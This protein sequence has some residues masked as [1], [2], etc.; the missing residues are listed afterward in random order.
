MNLMYA[1]DKSYYEWALK[2]LRAM[3]KDNVYKNL[4]YNSLLYLEMI[5]YNENC[6]ASFLADTLHVARSAVTVKINELVSK[7]LVI[8]TPSKTDKRVSYLKVSPAVAKDYKRIDDS[9]L[10]ATKEIE[11]TYS[12]E[13]IKA[14]TEMLEII[15]KHYMRGNKYEK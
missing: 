8:K 15:Q 10:A 3:N 6:T 7:G 14:F 11:Q 13:E 9:L 5:L 2:N 12:K 4:T 1:L